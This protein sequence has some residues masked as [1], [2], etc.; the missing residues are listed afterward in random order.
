EQEGWTLETF[1]DKAWVATREVGTFGTD[2]KD[3]K[4]PDK[5]TFVVAASPYANFIKFDKTTKGNWKGAYGSAGYL[6]S[7]FNGLNEGR[8]ADRVHDVEK[9]P[10]YLAELKKEGSSSY[11]WRVDPVN[12]LVSPDGTRR[13]STCDYGDNA[14]AYFIKLKETRFF[15]LAL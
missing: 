7:A 10:E 1:D 15:R 11:V 12:S 4:F 3:A 8:V 2:W 9:L 5:F 6:L 14:F 13:A